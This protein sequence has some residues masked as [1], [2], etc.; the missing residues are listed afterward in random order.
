MRRRLVGIFLKVSNKV[1]T[2]L[3]TGKRLEK[4]KNKLAEHN[5]R[6]RADCRKMVSEDC[7]NALNIR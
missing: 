5:I 7:K 1:I 3:R 6:N 2:R 4:I